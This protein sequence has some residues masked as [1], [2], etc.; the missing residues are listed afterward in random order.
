MKVKVI[1][2]DWIIPIGIA[3]ILAIAINKFLFFQ[4]S[5]PTP[6]MYPTIK[7]GDRIIV[8]RI[9]DKSKLKRG[10]IIVFYS[11]EEKE[12][13]I[14][15]LIGLPGDKVKVNAS[16]VFINGKK[17]EEPYV[18]NGDSLEKDFEVPNNHYLFFGDNRAA[19]LDSRRWDNPYI[20][21]SHI[22]G[23]ARF[24]VYPFK[25]FGKFVVGQEAL[26]Y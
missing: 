4:V 13:M 6:S 20:E 22:K 24:I 26:E 17:Q 21:S 18:V 11:D 23:K 8:T 10:E 16:G 12:T 15:R 2:S 3:I 19:S 25:R 7:V 14:K 9:Y 1:I 5:V